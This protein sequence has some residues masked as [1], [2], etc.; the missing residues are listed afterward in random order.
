VKDQFPELL[1]SE[2][3]FEVG[4]VF[5]YH[6]NIAL[7]VILLNIM[8]YVLIKKYYFNVFLA[9]LGNYLLLFLALQIIS[10]LAL[11]YFA[12][13]PWAQAPHILLAT[14]MFGL[15]FYIFLSAKKNRLIMN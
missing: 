10:G 2:W 4:R 13:S 5:V 11:N 8:L 14:L 1:R 12:L 15:Q 9:Y 7:L 6:K 3:I